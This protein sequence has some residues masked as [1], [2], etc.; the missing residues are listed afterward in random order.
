MGAARDAESQREA[1]RRWRRALGEQDADR[2]G[3]FRLHY[4]NMIRAHRSRSG[5]DAAN[6]M[7]AHLVKANLLIAED[8]RAALGDLT[9]W[10]SPNDA[11]AAA[12][13]PTLSAKAE[14]HRST[15]SA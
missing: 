12:Q 2:E 8:V 4:Q 7:G 14:P 11:A 15:G 10:Q 13:S 6:S 1:R 5:R 9:S 3:W